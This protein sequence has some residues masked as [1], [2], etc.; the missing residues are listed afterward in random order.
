MEE[1]DSQQ[2]RNG[3]FRYLVDPEAETRVRQP[4]PREAGD[5]ERPEDL[6]RTPREG[7]ED[8]P[9]E[10]ARPTANWYSAPRDAE[11]G[12]AVSGRRKERKNP[13]TAAG[14][15]QGGPQGQGQGPARERLA[16]PPPGP[17]TDTIQVPT[18]TP[19]EG[20]EE[21]PGNKD[22]EIEEEG[23]PP[24]EPTKEQGKGETSGIV[25]QALRRLRKKAEEEKNQEERH[26]LKVWERIQEREK[27][28][29][30]GN[31]GVDWQTHMELQLQHDGYLR[32]HDGI[33]LGIKMV[34]DLRV[35]AEEEQDQSA[36]A[37]RSSPHPRSPVSRRTPEGEE[38]G[39]TPQNRQR[40]E[41]GEGLLAGQEEGSNDRYGVLQE[42]PS[43]GQEAEPSRGA[44][45]DE[46]T[47]E[48]SQAPGQPPHKG[49]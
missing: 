22:I 39:G 33:E 41:E 23:Q 15:R 17:A 37:S 47:L 44:Q 48:D 43:P 24:G 9:A 36:P 1:S 8:P 5:E 42:G 46:P 31:G 40:T 6:P 4:H 26:T 10:R 12:G 19:G 45:E 13:G 11:I 29:S 7:Q 30:E 21:D 34:I 32:E 14:P 18:S 35:Q 20:Y 27:S 28:F 49:R 25:S 38:S 3:E 16:S 2:R